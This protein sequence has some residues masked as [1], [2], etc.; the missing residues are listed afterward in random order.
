[1]ILLVLVHVI[2]NARLQYKQG[3]FGSQVKVAV[4]GLGPLGLFWLV[5]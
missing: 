2:Y 5:Y 1:M 3:A 4:R